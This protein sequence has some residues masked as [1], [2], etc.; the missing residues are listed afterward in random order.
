M[1]LNEKTNLAL[2]KTENHDMHLSTPSKSIAHV[3][4]VTVQLSGSIDCLQCLMKLLQI[5]SN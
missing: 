5:T 1:I 4:K 3:E 2:G